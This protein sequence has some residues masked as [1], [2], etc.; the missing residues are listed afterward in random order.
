MLPQSQIVL[1]QGHRLSRIRTSTADRCVPTRPFPGARLCARCLYA[2][3]HTDTR[4]PHPSAALIRYIQFVIDRV[5]MLQFYKVTPIMVFDGNNLP[6]KSGTE[7]ERHSSRA[8]NKSKGMQALRSDNRAAAVEYFQRAVDVTPLM[9]HKC[10]KA[11]RKMGV[12][13]I[14][15]PYEADAQLAYLNTRNF[16]SAVITED[17]DI[18]AFG[19]KVV[20]F[21]MDKEGN[22]EEYRQKLLGAC[23]SMNLTGWRPEHL[24]QMCIF[25]GCDYLKSLSGM[26]IRFSKVLYM[27]ALYSKYPRAL[28]F[29][30]L[31]RHQKG[32]QYNASSQHPQLGARRVLRASNKKLSAP[33]TLPFVF[34]VCPLPR[35]VRAIKN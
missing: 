32:L 28:N 14:V 3:L 11:L 31:C 10:I 15:A 33:G 13:C 18:I 7:N 22:G 20:F 25:A 1:I 9:A 23:S 34:F 24:T 17:S 8:E 2:R 19:A 16:V 27:V 26:G 12:E 5:K 29:E 30:N 6:S 4:C 21:K 35:S